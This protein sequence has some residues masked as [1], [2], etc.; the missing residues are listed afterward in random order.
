VAGTEARWCFIITD[1]KGPG[2]GFVP[3]RVNENDARRYLMAGNGRYA[4]PWEWGDTREE[5]EQVCADANRRLGHGAEVVKDIVASHRS[6]LAS[7]I[8]KLRSGNIIII[9]ESGADTVERLAIERDNDG[10]VLSAT[11]TLTASGSEVDL[12]TVDWEAPGT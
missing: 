12:W 3:S 8:G 4:A 7:A 1:A 2:G 11:A 10:H 5:A 9:D 6:A